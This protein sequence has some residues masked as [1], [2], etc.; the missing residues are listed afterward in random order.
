VRSEWPNALPIS[1]TMYAL[2]SEDLQQTRRPSHLR[3]DTSI[4]KHGLRHLTFLLHHDATAAEALAEL[5]PTHL[6]KLQPTLAG[7]YDEAHQ[8]HLDTQ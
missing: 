2:P 5:W 6:T 3:P 7:M 4:L 1:F 8:L